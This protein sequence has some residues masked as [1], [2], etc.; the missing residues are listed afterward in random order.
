MRGSIPRVTEENP[1]LRFDH[2]KA[3]PEG[4]KA[5]RQVEAF[6]E[7]CSIEKPLRELVKIRASQINGCA[8]CLVMHTTDARKL[9]ESDARMHLL[10]AWHETDA[11]TP[12]E[13]AALA[14]TDAVTNVSTSHVP[15]D[16]YDDVRKHFSSQE[17][18]DLTYAIAAINVWN[19]LAIATRMEPAVPARAETVTA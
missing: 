3:S 5:L 2:K 1:M 10:N 8:Y 9:G 14:W 16:L 4:Y 18:G 15:D 19:R 12:R 11:F 17:M 6:L 7:T 13:K